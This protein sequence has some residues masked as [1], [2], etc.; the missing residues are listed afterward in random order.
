MR[1]G[2]KSGLDL[3][4]CFHSW[5]SWQLDE[6]GRSNVGVSQFSAVEIVL[7]EPNSYAKV[8]R[9][10]AGVA[11]VVLVIVVVMVVLERVERGRV[12]RYR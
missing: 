2:G 4:D 8:Q 10:A 12:W 9:R 11:G 6:V 7:T 1:G 5:I 3:S